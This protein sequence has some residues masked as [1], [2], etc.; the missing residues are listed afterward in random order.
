VPASPPASLRLFGKTVFV[1][2]LTQF[3][4]SAGTTPLRTFGLANIATDNTLRVSAFLDNSTG[5]NRIVASRVERIDAFPASDRHI[6]QGRV[7]LFDTVG[8]TYTVLGN[9]TTGLTVLTN[10][11]TTSY[12]NADG[13]AM[14]QAEFFALLAANQG[15][16]KSTVVRARGTAGSPT[17]VMIANEVRIQPTIDN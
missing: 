9:L 3:R 2:S 12:A 13:S 6:L 14:T 17:V 16:G 15:T 10:I 1:N 4:D 7:D 8:P 11:S 5:S